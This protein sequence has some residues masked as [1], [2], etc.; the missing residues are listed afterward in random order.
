[1]EKTVEIANNLY[2]TAEKAILRN[3]AEAILLSVEAREMSYDTKTYFYGLTVEE[4]CKKALKIYKMSEDWL[5]LMG[6]SLGYMW[7]DVIEWANKIT[8]TKGDANA[9][10]N[11]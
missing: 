10:S 5:P 2:K 3:F 6:L 8:E 1:M 7:N 4:A 11:L 9:G